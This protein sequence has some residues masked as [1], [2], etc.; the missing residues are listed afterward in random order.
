MSEVEILWDELQKRNYTSWNIV[1]LITRAQILSIEEPQLATLMSGA[2]GTNHAFNNFAQRM[3]SIGD[4]LNNQG[5]LVLGKD[6]KLQ[7]T[8]YGF[9]GGISEIYHEF[10]RDL[11]QLPLICPTRLSLDKSKA[12]VVVVT[13]LIMVKAA[14]SST[15]I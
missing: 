6:G 4:L 13:F 12:V 3:Q 14:F 7:Q 11:S 9:G 2:G 8:S 15:I 5:L 1:S 10:M